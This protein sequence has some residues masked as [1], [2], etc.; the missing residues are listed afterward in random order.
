MLWL[1][2][3]KRILTE[4]IHK[5]KRKDWDCFREYES[6]KHNLIRYKCLSCY[7]DCSNKL[8]K[9]LK[10]SYLSYCWKQYLYLFRSIFSSHFLIA[11][12][13]I[14]T[15]SFLI[16]FGEVP[17][18]FSSS[19]FSSGFKVFKGSSFKVFK[20]YLY[21]FCLTLSFHFLISSISILISLFLTFLGKRV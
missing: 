13:S 2:C 8:D 6:V 5:T 7:K 4:G 16:F 14:L 11:S 10:R 18:I 3:T 12:I 19:W 20:W 1:Y 9:S 17:S 15:L 21:L